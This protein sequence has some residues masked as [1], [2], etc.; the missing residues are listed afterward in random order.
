V[1]LSTTLWRSTAAFALSCAGSTLS[2]FPPAGEIPPNAVFVLQGDSGGSG[3]F[4]REFQSTHAEFFT[5]ETEES[6]ER[7]IPVRIVEKNDS[8]LGH[9]MLV[10]ATGKLPLGLVGF[11]I[12]WKGGPEGRR[13]VQQGWWTVGAE[14]DGAAPILS[15]TSD[16][17]R[18]PPKQ[19]ESSWGRSVWFEFP[20]SST[21]DPTL[22]LASVV[23][24]EDGVPIGSPVELFLN[25]RSPS[26]YTGPCGRNHELPSGK[27]YLVDLT[28]IDA[29]GNRGR[30]LDQQFLIEV[31]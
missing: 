11:R 13:W 19:T 7:S 17:F 10:P 18:L 26:L 8:Y 23:E 27:Q 12:S 21:E 28:P 22:V 20:F 24:S 6:P 31:P 3:S 9:V 25:P 16:S 5:P 4:I 14:V 1:L 15:R 30:A 2:L 29:A